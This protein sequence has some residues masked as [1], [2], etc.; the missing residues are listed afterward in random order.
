MWSEYVELDILC[1]H[2]C[3]VRQ[4]KFFELQFHPA[5]Y[6]GSYSPLSIVVRKK[7]REMWLKS[8]ENDGVLGKHV[9]IDKTKL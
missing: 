9:A 5:E 1:H 4:G 3:S 6:S 8:F 2:L 7:R